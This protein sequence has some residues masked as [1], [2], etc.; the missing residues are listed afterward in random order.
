VFDDAWDAT[1]GQ[2]EELVGLHH[3]QL[4]CTLFSLLQQRFLKVCMTFHFF[5]S[6]PSFKSWRLIYWWLCKPAGHQAI[7][8]FF[9]IDLTSC[10]FM[11]VAYKR[12]HG[13]CE[14]LGRSN[15]RKYQ[16]PSQKINHFFSLPS[17]LL[18]SHRA[19]RLPES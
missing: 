12:E 14:E 4:L 5:S 1:K 8:A 11:Q 16:V 18:L 17:H 9:K 3:V 7:R 15:I 19:G 10:I 6:L 2:S 13:D